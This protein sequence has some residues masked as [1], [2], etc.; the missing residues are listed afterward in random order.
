MTSFSQ[1]SRSFLH[2][3]IDQ[4]REGAVLS[5]RKDFGLDWYCSLDNYDGQ[6]LSPKDTCVL[7]L[8]QENQ[9]IIALNFSYV[10]R[11]EMAYSF[12]YAVTTLDH[13]NKIIETVGTSVFECLNPAL[14]F[15]PY[16][17]VDNTKWCFKAFADV[18]RQYFPNGSVYMSG[19]S[20]RGSYHLVVANYVMTFE[21]IGYL[22]EIA[23]RHDIFDGSV[24]GK[25]KTMKCVNQLK[26][27]E[28]H[29]AQLIEQSG[30]QKKAN[31]H[32][33]FHTQRP[34]FGGSLQAHVIQGNYESG[35]HGVRKLSEELYSKLVDEPMEVVREYT[36]EETV[37]QDETV[38]QE[39][40]SLV[41][42]MTEF[43]FPKDVVYE[44]LDV[45]AK[46]DLLPADCTYGMRFK[47]LRFVKFNI[48]MRLKQ[49]TDF[50]VFGKWVSKL[51]GSKIS[52]DEWSGMWDRAEAPVV[53]NGVPVGEEFLDAIFESCSNLKTAPL[54]T[55]FRE[56]T[57]LEAENTGRH[58]YEKSDL[59]FTKKFNVLTGKTC[60]GKTSATLGA[61]KERML[62]G[63]LI[64]WTTVRRSLTR[65]MDTRLKSEGYIVLSYLN[66][67]LH[68][69]DGEEFDTLLFSPMSFFRF[70][71]FKIDK[72]KARGFYLVLDET[73]TM[74]NDFMSCKLHTAGPI[75]NR[76][77]NLANLVGLMNAAKNVVM[78]DAFTTTATI[79][80]AKRV[81]PDLRILGHTPDEDKTSQY[82]LVKKKDITVE[83]IEFAR[84][85][86]K[87][88]F[89]CSKARYS[90]GDKKA[91][92]D[93]SG[94][95]V[96]PLNLSVEYMADLLEQELGW[97]RGKEF[98][99][100]L[101][102]NR[103]EY[104]QKERDEMDRELEEIGTLWANP[105]VRLILTS[106]VITVGVNFAERGVFDKVFGVYS[107]FLDAR[108]FWQAMDR[109]RFPKSRVATIH[110]QCSGMKNNGF[111]KVPHFESEVGK[112][113]SKDMRAEL[114]CNKRYAKKMFT[115]FAE[116]G[117]YKLIASTTSVAQDVKAID[118]AISSE[119]FCV[120]WVY[121]QDWENRKYVDD[122]LSGE[123]E[124]SESRKVRFERM[125][126]W[127]WCRVK[128]HLEVAKKS[129]K[130]S[131]EL[132]PE[133]QHELAKNTFNTEGRIMLEAIEE[134]NKMP[135]VVKL[136]KMV[137]INQDHTGEL[138]PR[139]IYPFELTPEVRAEVD[140]F[141][142]IEYGRERNMLES[143]LYFVSRVFETF[144]GKMVIKGRQRKDTRTGK[145]VAKQ[146]KGDDGKPYQEYFVTEF[147]QRFVAAYRYA[148]VGLAG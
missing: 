52:L 100:Y 75:D 81:S 44:D 104:T 119:N 122:L 34:M 128:K 32:R 137:G 85:G 129:K 70:N 58:Y 26:A 98:K 83:V 84:N 148:R 95:K 10:K 82:V 46:L 106:S 38:A 126:F 27:A 109:V 80:L 77:V 33:I 142:T 53:E 140:K 5:T 115:L 28:E 88:Y 24:Y 118:L 136:L 135:I 42:D 60:S 131:D 110:Y 141:I 13:L 116:L 144:F 12:M 113:L 117:H 71:D 89:F 64:V 93:D 74:L 62:P 107:P 16:F 114:I 47:M 20:L 56:S 14:P 29:A 22:K 102:G 78:M 108:S 87:G 76:E 125:M 103:D 25:W 121:N 143:K 11:G 147:G 124:D 39:K 2:A 127:H 48:P 91:F 145:M 94:T 86:G 123:I 72:L 4:T 130:Y 23:K 15:K 41:E 51:R 31:S 3:S 17:D 9:R 8:E 111:V 36:Q 63:E 61:I 105:E 68:E 6:R 19:S 65:D 146:V 96:K 54:F 50:M 92:Q 134:L 59:D 120:E 99:V 66:G 55:K 21:Q 101:G 139:S 90:D 138:L 73:E 45:F 67:R 37:A 97:T 57:L 133:K 1:R 69:L 18:I 132:T 49:D 40:V 7:K 112:A 35:Y 43:I 30:K 79:N